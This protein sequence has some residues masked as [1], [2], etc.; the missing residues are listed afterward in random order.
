MF[1]WDEGQRQ[2]DVKNLRPLDNVEAF[3]S[4]HLFIYHFIYFIL[5]FYF[6]ILSCLFIIFIV[7]F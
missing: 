7:Y 3:L 1:G 6:Y 5:S 4:S 2:Y